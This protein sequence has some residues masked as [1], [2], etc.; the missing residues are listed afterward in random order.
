[1]RIV[2]HA[3]L[4][5]KFTAEKNL[6]KM[7][8]MSQKIWWLSYSYQ[9]IRYIYICITQ[10][11]ASWNH[12]IKCQRAKQTNGKPEACI[13]RVFCHSHVAGMT[14]VHRNP[15]CTMAAFRAVHRDSH[16]RTVSYSQLWAVQPPRHNHYVNHSIGYITADLLLLHNKACITIAIWLRYDDTTAHSTT[17]KV[18]EITTYVRLDCDTTTIWLRWKSD[19]FIFCSHRI[20]SNGSRHARYVVVG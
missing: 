9:S 13:Q 11:K 15:E 8:N 17:A 18:T 14:H 1:M 20:A 3:S 6:W 19:M 10:C 5:C 2:K 16:R 4:Y 7:V 12:K